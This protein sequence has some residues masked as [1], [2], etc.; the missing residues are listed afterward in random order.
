MRLHTATAPFAAGRRKRRPVFKK[1]GR[2]AAGACHM[3]KI[4]LN[5]LGS[6]VTRDSFELCDREFEIVYVTRQSLVSLFSPSSLNPL[7]PSADRPSVK[8]APS[9]FVRKT[10]NYDFNKSA[11]AAFNYAA[12]LIVDLTEERHSTVEAVNGHYC[13]W[14][15]YAL[16]YSNLRNY[17][18]NS[19]KPFDSQ[20]S[21][22]LKE[23]LPAFASFLNSFPQVILHEV[24]FD[25]SRA[26][27][28]VDSKR[29]NRE[30]KEIYG[31]I[32]AVARNLEVISIEPEFRIISENHKWGALP[33]HFVD[34]YYGEFLRK[35]GG[36]L[37]TELTVCAGRTLQKTE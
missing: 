16:K 22:L 29:L 14:T 20:Y 6:C 11:L 18:K 17:V 37:K 7:P 13:T 33:I 27:E 10:L 4:K 5:I 36:A 23:A 12:P 15:P 26:W 34:A 32:K 3:E 9:N 8:G 25:E 24:Y 21:Q 28:F 30:I 19:I 31:F 35:L 1:H 2:K